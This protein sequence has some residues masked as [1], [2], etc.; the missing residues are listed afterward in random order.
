MTELSGRVTLVAWPS[1]SA[2]CTVVR[3]PDWTVMRLTMSTIGGPTDCTLV[4]ERRG[5]DRPVPIG[6]RGPD[7]AYP[8]CLRDA[9][10]GACVAE[11]HD[12][13]VRAVADLVRSCCRPCRCTRTWQLAPRPHL[14][15]FKTYPLRQ[16]G[17]VSVLERHCLV[18][19]GR[20]LPLGRV[21]S[22]DPIPGERLACC[23]HEGQAPDLDRCAGRYPRGLVVESLSQL[24]SLTVGTFAP[25]KTE[26][27]RAQ[28]ELAGAQLIVIGVAPAG[29]RV[30]VAR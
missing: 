27:A 6:I 2:S 5:L 15:L 24:Q 9:V 20:P 16:S 13:R 30:S 22:R 29:S 21:D 11:F 18:L 17:P 3:S 12:H 4:S 28:S 19:R 26:P 7:L 1:E 23:L 14:H 25:S 10:P 8:I